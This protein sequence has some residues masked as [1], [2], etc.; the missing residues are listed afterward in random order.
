M[1]CKEARFSRRE[2]KEIEIRIEPD[3]NVKVVFA[4]MMCNFF[5]IRIEPDWNVKDAMQA[6]ISRALA[7]E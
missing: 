6:A 1:E 7:L 4:A 2:L 5:L 3:W